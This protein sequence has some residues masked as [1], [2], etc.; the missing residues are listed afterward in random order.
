MIHAL[1]RAAAAAIILLPAAGFAQTSATPAS[2]PSTA[3]ALSRAEATRIDPRIKQLHTQLG[4][5][6]AQQALWDQYAQVMRENAAAMSRAGD[7]RAAKLESM[8]AIATMQSYA[9]LSKLHGENMEKL[10]AAFT[11]LYNSFDATQKQRADSVFRVKAETHA[12]ARAAA[13]ATP[14]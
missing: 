4:I 8:D 3:P 7:A 11:T 1:R 6:P 9:D 12:A 5:T 13:R 10:A 14:R 2:V